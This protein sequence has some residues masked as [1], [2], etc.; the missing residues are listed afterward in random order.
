[1]AGR[2]LPDAASGTMLHLGQQSRV[3]ETN[4]TEAISGE[5]TDLPTAR[6][7]PIEGRRYRR[8]LRKRRQKE[9]GGPDRHRATIFIPRHD[10]ASPK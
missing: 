3:A 8:P 4:R 1:M 6:L 5:S 9:Q 10:L 7:K 2:E